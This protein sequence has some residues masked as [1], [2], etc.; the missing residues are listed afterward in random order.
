MPDETEEIAATVKADKSITIPTWA[1]P[2]VLGIVFGG[3]TGT[4]TSLLQG[5][6]AQT[7]AKI[8]ALEARLDAHEKLEGHPLLERRVDDVEEVTN[9]T[10]EK[11]DALSDMV[12]TICVEMGADCKRP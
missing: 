8:A 12:F 5:N 7:E 2:A 6:S 11:L 10:E 9:E 1:L 3:A 4:G